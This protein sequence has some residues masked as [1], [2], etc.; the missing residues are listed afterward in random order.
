MLPA[1]A[2][3][4][5]QGTGQ[6]NADRQR[7]QHHQAQNIG[8]VIHLTRF[9]HQHMGIQRNTQKTLRTLFP[10]QRLDNLMIEIA[11]G[12]FTVERQAVAH[13]N[14][15]AAVG[16]QAAVV[17]IDRSV[18]HT[19]VIRHLIQDGFNLR[20]V[21]VAVI[22]ERFQAE[23]HLARQRVRQFLDLFGTGHLMA[24]TKP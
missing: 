2:A 9:R 17:G 18:Q 1:G 12:T 7:Q 16:H 24:K 5:Q 10:F 8:G 22:H 23:R 4:A 15:L 20:A 11:T 6:D 14:A 13:I 21:I 3:V 19:A